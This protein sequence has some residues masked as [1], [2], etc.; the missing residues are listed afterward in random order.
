MLGSQ[1][2]CWWRLPWPARS[3]LAIGHAD[4]TPG[5]LPFSPSSRCFLSLARRSMPFSTMAYRAG[6]NCI[7]PSAGSSPLHSAWPCWAGL[8]YRH[9]WMLGRRLRLRL[10]GVCP[11]RLRFWLWV[12]AWVRWPL[13]PPAILCLGHLSTLRSALWIRAIKPT[14]LLPMGACFGVIRRWGLCALGWSLCSVVWPFGVLPSK[15]DASARRHRC[16]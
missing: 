10:R 8:G 11:R 15:R 2:G 12:Q 7:A 9:C 16:C 4:C 14:K 5:S 1:P 6:R 3:L 13:L